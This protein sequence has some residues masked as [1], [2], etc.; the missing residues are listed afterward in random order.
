MQDLTQRL[1]DKYAEMV[2]SIA[3]AI[4]D[5]E[6]T[7]EIEKIIDIIIDTPEMEKFREELRSA[8]I[9]TK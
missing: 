9:V 5:V 8:G 6:Q 3:D 7:E 1:W 4:D 2:Q